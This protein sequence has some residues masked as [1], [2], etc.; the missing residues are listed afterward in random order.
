[1]RE[2]RKKGGGVNR[3]SIG[4]PAWAGTDSLVRERERQERRSK[5]CFFCGEGGGILWW[6]IKL[7]KPI[8]EKIWTEL[9]ND[10]GG[11]NSTSIDLYK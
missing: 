7:V 2:V 3:I 11:K 5:D 8:W 9:G 6:D 10:G 4:S 1:M